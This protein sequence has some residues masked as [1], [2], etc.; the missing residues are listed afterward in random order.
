MWPKRCESHIWSPTLVSARRGSW[1]SATHPDHKETIQ[2]Q[3]RRTLA[4]GALSAIALAGF[5]GAPANA[6]TTTGTDVTVDAATC[7]TLSGAAADTKGAFQA[8]QKAFNAAAAK[9]A[10]ADRAAARADQAH[11]T[12]AARKAANGTHGKSADAK[13]A[14]KAAHKAAAH[15][16][17]KGTH[18]RSS[19]ARERLATL[20]TLANDAKGAWQDAKAAWNEVKDACAATGT[21]AEQPTEPTEPTEPAV[22]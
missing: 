6:D 20:K 10:K 21:G 18:G 2:M 9:Q 19:A 1:G 15:K 16:T 5:A 7:T 11:S 12:K 13:A 22:A 4:A 14:H 3:I 8:A 17:A